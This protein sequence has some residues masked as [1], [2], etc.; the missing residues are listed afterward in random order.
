M[1]S[2]QEVA[3]IMSVSK[4][5]AYTIMYQMPHMEQPLRVSE[6]ALRDWI[7]GK[8]VYPVLNTKRKRA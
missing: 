5:S 6:R 7:N 8:L 4:R 2:P 3:D 1:L